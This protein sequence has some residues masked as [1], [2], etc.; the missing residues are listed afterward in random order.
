M[1]PAPYRLT[2]DTIFEEVPLLPCLPGVAPL[3]GFPHSFIGVPCISIERAHAHPDASDPRICTG[4]P[5][6]A[7]ERTGVAVQG[8]ASEAD[9]GRTPGGKDEV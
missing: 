2:A 9:I 1:V 5:S 7:V 3:Q 4:V 8:S 6:T